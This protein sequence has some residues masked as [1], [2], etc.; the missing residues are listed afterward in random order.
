MAKSIKLDGESFEAL[1][2]EML[3]DLQEDVKET[4]ENVEFYKN[5][6]SKQF[7]PEQY[8]ELFNEALKI[9]GSAR[10][11]VLKLLTL[12]RDRVKAKEVIELSKKETGDY[13]AEE[14]SELKK[15]LKQDE[16]E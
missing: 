7:G 12:I 16:D 2:N 5:L 10:D 3:L 6:V 13:S 8:G 1:I 14:I 9:K 15:Q 4:K 11:R